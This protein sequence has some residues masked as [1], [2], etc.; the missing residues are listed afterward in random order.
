MN[1]QSILHIP[2][3]HYAHGIDEENVLIRIRVGKDDIKKCTLFY[4]DRSCKQT[5]VIFSKVDMRIIASD[6]MFDYFQI[7]VNSEYKRLCYYF[8]LNDGI[9]ET[10]YYGDIFSKETVDDRSEYY[11][12]PFNHRD[13]IAKVPLWAKDTV[14]YNIF[15]DSFATGRK[16]I[17]KTGSEIEYNNHIVKSKNGGTIKGIYENVDYIKELGINCIY[18]NPIFVAGEYHKYDLIDYYSIDPCF[19]TNEDFKLMVNLFHENNIK[20]VI[21]GVFNHCG[22][23]FFAFD[24]VIKNQENSQYADWFYGLQFPITRP[25]NMDIIPTYD[26]FGYERM[27]PKLNTEHQDVID[28][29]CDVCKYWLSEYNIDG[30]RLDVASEVNAG[31]WREFRK[32]AKSIN[33]HSI[34]IG[35]IWESAQYWL[36]GSQ[37]DSS[38]NYDF[39]KHCRR[40]FAEESIDAKEFDSRVTNMLMRYKQNI[41]YAQLNILDSHDVSRFLSLCDGDTRKYKLAVLFQMC[42]V[43][44]PCIFYGD[45]QGIKGI[46][47]H[48]YRHPMRFN[49]DG[50]MFKFFKEVIALRNDEIVLRHGDYCVISNERGSGLYVFSRGM[51]NYKVVIAINAVDTSVDISNIM[52]IKGEILLQQGLDKYKINGYGFVVIKYKLKR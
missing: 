14:M 44:M 24:D 13:D 40:F 32:A 41:L 8:Y 5:P 30:W 1:Y 37:F 38:M 50:D 43:G 2:M 48:E 47:E 49:E 6:E 45:E 9:E 16:Y 39:R 33:P 7:I 11:Q 52:D 22:W 29:F 27:M 17:S 42:F 12:F 46:L 21:D 10:L 19:G 28:Y 26:C 18:I 34:L 15:P 51:D 25:D 20:V 4:G 23:H 35:E 36:D 31:F 3:S